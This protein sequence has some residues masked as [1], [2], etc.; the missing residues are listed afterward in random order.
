[1][2]GKSAR[3]KGAPSQRRV[4][5]ATGTWTPSQ[6]RLMIVTM[7]LAAS[8]RIRSPVAICLLADPV[9]STSGRPYSRATI[10]AWH[11]TPPASVTA[12]A[13]RPNTGV[14]LVEVKGATRISPSCKSSSCSMSRITRAGPSTT[15]A[16]PAIPGIVS[17]AVPSDVWSHSCTRSV[18]IPQCMIV[19]GSVTAS[20]AWSSAGGGAQRRSAS[21]IRLRRS[22]VGG[23][24]LGPRGTPTPPELHCSRSSS[25]AE[26]TSP[27]CRK[28]TSSGS[29]RKA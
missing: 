12:A 22:T 26:R 29:V 7:P 5:I 17:V 18:V 3:A 20:G 11:M 2:V 10:A 23:H 16:E 14:Q 25:S 24:K 8:T 19:T 1:M 28:N 21:K 13:I 15:P 4:A 27:W 9:P 6:H